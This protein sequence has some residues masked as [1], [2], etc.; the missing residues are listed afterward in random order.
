MQEADQLPVVMNVKDVAAVIG[1]S[2]TTARNLMKR[3]DFPSFFVT[4]SMRRVYRE[5]FLEWLSKQTS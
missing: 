3:E 1:V 5:K 4:P 2:E